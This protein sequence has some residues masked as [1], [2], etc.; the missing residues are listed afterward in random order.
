MVCP[1]FFRDLGFYIPCNSIQVQQS[2]AQ[3]E[4][5]ALVKG[6]QAYQYRVRNNNYSKL[7]MQ[8]IPSSCLFAYHSQYIHAADSLFKSKLISIVCAMAQLQDF[9]LN[10]TSKENY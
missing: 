1:Q 6:I 2:D 5:N 4:Y 7:N 10:Q 9:Q 8:S 3:T